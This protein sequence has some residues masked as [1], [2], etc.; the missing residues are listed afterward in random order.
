MNYY[1]NKA[2]GLEDEALRHD[3]NPYGRRRSGSER[4]IKSAYGPWTYRC[5]NGDPWV[6][7]RR[8]DADSLDDDKLCLPYAWDPNRTDWSKKAG[9]PKGP[10]ILFNLPELCAAAPSEPVFFLEGEKKAEIAAKRLGLVA[11]TAIQGAGNST[12]EAMEDLRGRVVFVVPDNNDKGRR[13][14]TKVATQLH[15]VAKEVRIVKLPRLEQDEDLEEWLD[16]RG[17]SKEELLKLAAEAPVF[18]PDNDSV[19]I[20]DF[21]AYLPEHR[22]IFKPTGALWPASGVNA[23][24]HPVGDKPASVWL[25]AN[26]RVE[27][28]TWC[29][30]MPTLIKDKLFTEDGAWVDR[31]GCNTYNL[32][33]PPT[34]KPGSASE[35]GLWVDLVRE[36]YPNDAEHI[37]N[38]LA[39]RRQR[40]QEKI[41]HMLFMG[42][43]PGIGKDSIIEGLKRAIGPWNFR[44]ISPAAIANQFNPYVQSVVV[45]ITELRDLGDSNRVAFYEATKWMLASPPA[46]LRVNEKHVKAYYVPNVCG[47]IATTNHKTDGLY[48]PSDDRRHYIAWSDLEAS[49]RSASE[50]TDWYKWLD[51]GGDRHVAAF[52]DARDLRRFDPKAPPEKTEAFWEMVN[53]SRYPEEGELADVLESFNKCAVTLDMV[54]Q[55]AIERRYGELATFLQD[56]AKRRVITG[57]MDKAG[58][59]S[60][61]NQ[62]AKDR[63]W[64]IGE[65]RCVIYCPKGLSTAE[66]LKLVGDRIKQGEGLSLS[67]AEVARRAQAQIN[68]GEVM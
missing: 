23:R 16:D 25:D 62:D 29:P 39:H 24:V 26:A 45:L 40:P 57:R 28:M 4:W 51:S 52:L 17:G 59:S 21:C 42:G 37:L 44:E 12:Q 47:V 6:I 56:R 14:A 32:Y 35:A 2:A 60:V 67:P 33:R 66:A 48:L 53:A 18:E 49:P 54:S 31:P 68:E 27:Q 46:T 1:K 5:K 36:V 55:R 43:P 7:V 22:Y 11:T 64:K 15:G 58:Y 20:E 3:A 50:W 65:R 19:N 30:G 63:L 34:I 38:Y 41:N 13:H 9:L 8:F 61:S 10:R